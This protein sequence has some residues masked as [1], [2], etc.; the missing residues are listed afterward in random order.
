VEPD[1]LEPDESVEVHVRHVDDHV[2]VVDKQAGIVVHPG[3]GVVDATLVQG[4]LARFPELAT[5]G[6][7]DR[8]GIVHRL[9]RGTSG[10]LMVARTS[11]AYG[12]LVDQLADR[13]V[14]RLYDVVAAGLFD[15]ERGLIDAP[16]GR[17]PRDATRRAVV[18]DGRPARTHYE[19]VERF[20]AAAMTRVEC[21]LETGRTH[22]I[23]AHLAAIDH[24]VV[25]DERY[26]GPPLAQLSRPFLH[27]KHLGFDHPVDGTRLTFDAEL[28]TDLAAALDG[29]A[30]TEAG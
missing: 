7:P 5:V 13:T 27:A 20:D 28:P 30:V 11:E 9:D 29:L 2:I 1:G 24:P 18:G 14:S 19:V 12:S 23:R 26:G 17:S 3:S 22:Q 4:L 8:P 21:R 16:L 15:S 6:Q 10:L 25:G